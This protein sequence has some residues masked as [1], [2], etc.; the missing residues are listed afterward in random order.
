MSTR[1]STASYE[2]VGVR[3]SHEE[4]NLTGLGR[5]I[6]QTFDLNPA[7]PLLPLGY[8]ANVL[9]LS[10]T[11]GLAISTDGVGT[12]I[13]VAQELGRF[14]TIG[15]DCV[16]MNVNDIVC[17]G[18]RP[19]AMVD[20]IAVANANEAFLGELAKGLYEG[21]RQAR[22]SIPGGEVAQIREMIQGKDPDCAFDLVGT[23]VGTVDPRK[24]IVGEHV[25]PGDVVVGLAST[26]VHS[27]GLTL[28][29]HALKEAG[30]GLE[31]R[32]SALERSV[33]DE[34]LTPT[35]IYV[36]EVV[37]MID[38]GLQIKALVHIT[39]DGFLNL[40]RVKAD[41][42]GYVL[43]NLPEPNPIFR[44]IQER[45]AVPDAEMFRVFNMGIGFCVVVAPSDSAGICEI[46][47]AHGRAAS[48]IGYVARDGRR[49][50]WLP[51]RGLVGRADRFIAA[52]EVPPP[53]G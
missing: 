9:P 32:V 44:L 36:P 16:A 37:E 47:R 42:I 14:D 33:G 29:R 5:W 30:L 52:D 25:V 49:S 51:Q 2:G 10:E 20:Y 6:N 3:A 21:A 31:D 18:A 46:A 27:N 11:L 19:L 26:G 13:L 40:Q 43:E 23:C 8:F 4:L 15:I 28:A 24:L 34:L 1:K 12:K 48:T 41:D 17:V 22:I 7:R 50:V 53:H 35:A 45:G 38:R 39:S